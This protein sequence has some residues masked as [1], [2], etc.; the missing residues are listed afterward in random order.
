SASAMASRNPHADRRHSRSARSTGWGSA[1][2]PTLSPPPRP[3]SSERRRRPRCF[4]S[5]VAPGRRDFA[6]VEPDILLIVAPRVV[7]LI[8]VHE[9]ECG[10]PPRL[11][12]P[13]ERAA[14][15]RGRFRGDEAERCRENRLRNAAEVL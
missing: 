12:H 2:S 15:E 7:H 8:P 6:G 14:P 4:S 1:L 10:T 13:E 5:S 3:A 9:R 11:A